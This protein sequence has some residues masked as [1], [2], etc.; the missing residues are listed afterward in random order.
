ML[1]RLLRPVSV[2][3]AAMAAI[4]PAPASWLA[5]EASVSQEPSAKQKLEKPEHAFIW[6]I[7]KEGL[8][9]SYLFGTMHVPDKRFTKF[10]DTVKAAFKNAD[11]VYTEL[12]MDMLTGGDTAAKFQS[13]GFYAPGEGSLADVL[14]DEEFE[15]LKQVVEHYGL[16]P[17]SL[18]QTMRP[19]MAAMTLSQ[20]AVQVEFGPGEALDQ[21]IWNAAKK[22]KKEIGGVETLDEQI[23]ALTVLTEEEATI[24][25]V[26]QLDMTVKDIASGRSR[27]QELAEHYLSGSEPGM[28]GYVLED[29]DPNNPIEVKAMKALLD[30]RNVR[31][32]ERSGKIMQKNAD[33]SYVF[34]FGTLHMLGKQN[35]VQLLRE[36]GFTVTR[37]TAPKEKKK[38][39]IKAIP[40]GR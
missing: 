38:A 34:V 19:F 10:N 1:T 30:D 9:T 31:M 32:A 40:I 15:K 12:D 29:F 26:K 14:N 25:L 11:G 37:L 13:I 8:K 7:E 33:K 17:I 23:E 28:L 27:M 22:A 6:K 39:S 3:V 16:Y 5:Q 36:H 2:A 35:V 21:K 18:I 24:A 4:F 20:L